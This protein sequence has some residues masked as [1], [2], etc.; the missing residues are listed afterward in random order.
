MSFGV[1]SL[2]KDTSFPRRRESIWTA[3]HF[4]RFREWIPAFAGMTVRG[5][6]RFSQMTPVPEQVGVSHFATYERRSCSGL[7]VPPTAAQCLLA[8]AR[9]RGKSL[10]VGENLW[11]VTMEGKGGSRTAPT[12]FRG[13]TVRCL[14]SRN[15]IWRPPP[16][17][18]PP[19]ASPRGDKSYSM[20][21]TQAHRVHQ[22]H[23][24][25]EDTARQVDDKCEAS[26][27]SLVSRFAVPYRISWP[28]QE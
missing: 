2:L 8:P 5:S 3:A 19:K 14:Q 21:D 28:R 18:Q 25:T 15:Q 24:G 10:A 9:R 22:A 23:C 27:E 17:P 11:V 7:I 16:C 4:Q 20:D 26:P 12:S 13:R 6:I 1:G